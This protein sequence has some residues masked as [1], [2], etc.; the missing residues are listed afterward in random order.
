MFLSIDPI[1]LLQR[2]LSRCRCCHRAKNSSFFTTTFLESC[3]PW[4][5]NEG[6]GLF[7]WSN[8]TTSREIYKDNCYR[9][10]CYQGLQHDIIWPFLSLLF[11]EKKGHVTSA[12]PDLQREVDQTVGMLAKWSLVSKSTHKSVVIQTL[13]GK[14]WKLN[15]QTTLE[16]FAQKK[17]P[18]RVVLQLPVNERK[19]GRKGRKGAEGRVWFWV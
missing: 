6:R 10:V 15:L 4:H 1:Y 11:C 16:G 8:H 13:Q 18:F 12:F 2:P 9:L 3:D 5:A 14:W 7:R 19:W 17:S